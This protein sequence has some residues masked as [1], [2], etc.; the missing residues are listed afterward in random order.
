VVFEAESLSNTS[1]GENH[2]HVDKNPP[3]SVHAW[4]RLKI[5]R[6]KLANGGISIALF[7]YRADCC[8]LLAS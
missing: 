3:F 7:V 5:D 2:N 4:W 6:A 8:L 1:C